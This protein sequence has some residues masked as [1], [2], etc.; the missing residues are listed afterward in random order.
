MLGTG[1]VEAPIAGKAGDEGTEQVL[2]ERQMW[3]HLLLAGLHT[4]YNLLSSESNF[5]IFKCKTFRLW[6]EKRQS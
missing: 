6:S 4:W 2:L 3:K 5:F 1:D